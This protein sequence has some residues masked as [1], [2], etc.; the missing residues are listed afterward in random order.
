MGQEKYN[1]TNNFIL[2]P[3]VKISRKKFM[4]DV[5][6]RGFSH[7]YKQ[8]ETGKELT[9]KCLRKSYI[10]QLKLF[11]MESGNIT[12]ITGHSDNAV[13]DGYYLDKVE[14]VKAAR[15]FQ[16]FKHEK[17]RENDLKELRE[18]ITT[19]SIQLNK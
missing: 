9:F 17:E 5:L 6:S 4:S 19:N 15:H 12:E 7:F 16:L 14:L 13:I 8:L 11:F 1:G 2:A 10:T 3:D 18:T